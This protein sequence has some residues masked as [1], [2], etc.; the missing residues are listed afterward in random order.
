MT[1]TFN[2]EALGEIPRQTGLNDSP[3]YQADSLRRQSNDINHNK[4][5]LL[6]FIASETSQNLKSF[7]ITAFISLMILNPQFWTS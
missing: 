2:S 5:D 6:A 1:V 7:R 4:L 3:C